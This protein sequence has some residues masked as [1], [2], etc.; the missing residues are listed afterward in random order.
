MADDKR[1]NVNVVEDD[2]PVQSELDS[3]NALVNGMKAGDAA[4]KYA[5]V[6]AVLEKSGDHE[7]ADLMRTLSCQMVFD[8]NEVATPAIERTKKRVME[9][10]QE[11]KRRHYKAYLG[12]ITDE[13]ILAVSDGKVTQGA[14]NILGTSF[15]KGGL[16]DPEISAVT[17]TC[18]LLLIPVIRSYRLTSGGPGWVI[19]NFLSGSLMKR[20]CTRWLI[21]SA[22][23]LSGI[24]RRLS[25]N[26]RMSRGTGCIS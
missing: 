15:V 23:I 24:T 11:R 10:I 3:F 4:D 5:A 22:S 13:E 26:S 25:V 1:K 2:V 14:T 18:L 8:G 9:A 16:Y 21:F 6:A 20:I 19:S 12:K 7:M 17:E